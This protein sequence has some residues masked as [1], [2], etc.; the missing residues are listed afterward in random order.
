MITAS[1]H[2]IT[3]KEARPPESINKEAENTLYSK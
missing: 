2:S 3:T 1:L